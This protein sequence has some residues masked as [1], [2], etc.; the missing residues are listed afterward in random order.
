MMY[1]I[2]CLIDA[3]MPLNM[4]CFLPVRIAVP[5]GS[6]LRPGPAVAVL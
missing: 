4:G 5:A 1:T 3:D 2:R 6:V